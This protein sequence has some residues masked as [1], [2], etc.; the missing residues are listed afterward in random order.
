MYA[1]YGTGGAGREAASLAV[2][3]LAARG[4]VP[5][6]VFVDDARDRST[7]V[8]GFP[9]LGFEA[10]CAP[11]HRCRPIVIAIGDGRVRERIDRRC[12]AAGLVLG[13]LLAP[14][15]RLLTHVTMGPGAIACDLSLITANVRIGR[16][17]RCDF[18][19][20]VAHDCVIGDYVTLSPRA[21]INGAVHLHHHVFIGASAVI[22]NG[23]LRKP[24]VVGEGAV[25][26]MGA[27]VT[28]DVEP[29][30]VVV[31]NPAR[32]VRRLPLPAAAVG[33]AN[34]RQAPALA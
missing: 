4:A 30:T 23:S 2:S 1:I 20:Y 32:I 24:L 11:A 16:G 12:A 34:S 33:S 9:V 13:S 15:A 3:A 25:V 26:G 28:R 8:N 31:G 19:S 6:I 17:F 7:E 18:A 10:L 5:D 27:V 21:S 14:T 22:R 29:Y